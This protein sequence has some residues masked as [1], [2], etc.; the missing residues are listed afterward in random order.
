MV[1]AIYTPSTEHS[2]D[3]CIWSW[4]LY[5]CH[6]NDSRA[7]HLTQ[8][9]WKHTQRWN[10]CRFMLIINYKFNTKF[11]TVRK[12]CTTGTLNQH[13]K[14]T[15]IKSSKD[16]TRNKNNDMCWYTCMSLSGL[17]TCSVFIIIIPSSHND[18]TKYI[19]KIVNPTSYFVKYL[20][21]R[22]FFYWIFCAGFTWIKT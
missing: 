21:L 8:I 9:T 14:E 12:S 4:I 7:S 20:L 13:I 16:N 15:K 11:E 17:I 3:C 2:C 6:S 22:I 18:S 1:V 5:C 19:N 10:V